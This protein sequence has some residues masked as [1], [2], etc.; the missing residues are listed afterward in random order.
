MQT[1]RSHISE[2]TCRLR[3]LLLLLT[4]GALATGPAMAADQTRA[5][6]PACGIHPPDAAAAAPDT[7]I[8]ALYQIVSGPANSA[9]DWAR[10]ARLHA[11]DALITPTQHGKAVEFAAAPQTLDQFIGLN[12]R[13][14]ASRGFYERETMHRFQRFGH[15]AHVWSG[16][17]TRERADGP[18]ERRGINSF[19]LLHDGQR[20]CVLSATWDMDSAAH[21]VDAF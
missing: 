3:S 21:R 10:L 4:L 6:K 20:W 15:I 8:K 2:G 1:I 12:E 14:F 9:K 16:F 13:L 11:P 17:E 18:A 7:L 5:E 19:Q